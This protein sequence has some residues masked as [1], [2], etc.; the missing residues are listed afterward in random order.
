MIHEP[1]CLAATTDKMVASRNV[2]DVFE[3]DD[4]LSASMQRTALR[5]QEQQTS[6]YYLA[7]LPPEGGEGEGRYLW[8]NNLA[9]V[10]QPLGRPRQLPSQDLCTMVYP[11]SPHQ[12]AGKILH[13]ISA[14]NNAS[15]HHSRQDDQDHA[16]A[17]AS[18]NLH[19]YDNSLILC[20]KK[21][22]LRSSDGNE[23][24]CKRILSLYMWWACILI[25]LDIVSTDG[26]VVIF[27]D[28]AFAPNTVMELKGDGGSTLGVFGCV[29]SCGGPLMTTPILCHK[30]RNGP[31]ESGSGNPC[32]NANAS[33]PSGQGTGTYDTMGSWDVSRVDKMDYSKFVTS[34]SIVYVILCITTTNYMNLNQ[35]VT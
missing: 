30:S 3:G 5:Q 1:T 18:V 13:S 16:Y 19:R 24:W 21:N 26:R 12:Y 17:G 34:L 11:Q 15:T 7:E 31:W 32:N 29:G 33:V 9:Q 20:D 27:A 6:Q 2:V 23:D 28:A 25:A 10:F 35:C 8:P 22:A 14:G 4:T